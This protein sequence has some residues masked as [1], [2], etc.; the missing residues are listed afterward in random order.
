MES[1]AKVC[2]DA[3]LGDSDE[4]NWNISTLCTDIYH[5]ALDFVNCVF[6]WTKREANMVAHE[7][8]KFVFNHSLPFSCNQSTLP[9]FVMVS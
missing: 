8:A 1:D 5:I 2:I 3:M 9:T 6:V 4:A 7:F